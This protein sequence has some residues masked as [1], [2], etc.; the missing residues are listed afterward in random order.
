MEEMS[1]T[2][3]G[4]RLIRLNSWKRKQDCKLIPEKVAWQS[5]KFKYLYGYNLTL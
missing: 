5:T 2:L 1:Q 3:P 4:R